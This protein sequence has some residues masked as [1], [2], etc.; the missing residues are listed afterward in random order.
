MLA[1]TNYNNFNK[2]VMFTSAVVSMMGPK[3]KS[4]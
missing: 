1:Y 4:C 2:S 3:L